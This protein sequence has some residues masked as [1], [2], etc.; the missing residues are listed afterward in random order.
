MLGTAYKLDIAAPPADGKA[1]DA[2]IELLAEVTRIHRSH[3]RLLKGQTSR[4]KIIAFDGIDEAE[5][6]R[7]LNQAI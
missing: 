7:R 6:R 4:S 2:C 1:N 3:I 5:L